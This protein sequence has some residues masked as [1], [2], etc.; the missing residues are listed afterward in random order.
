MILQ[1]YNSEDSWKF[2]GFRP[3]RAT[4]QIVP[5]L[6]TNAGWFWG[7]KNSLFLQVSSMGWKSL[8]FS[9]I[10]FFFP[11]HH[12]C[13]RHVVDPESHWKQWSKSNPIPSMGLAYLPTWMV[14]VYGFMVNNIPVLYQSHGWYGNGCFVYA[15]GYTTQLYEDFNQA[16]RRI[17]MNRLCGCNTLFLQNGH[18]LFLQDLESP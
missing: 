4:C 16:R 1:V 15:C 9:G 17:S 18:G 14:D 11:N 2:W 7:F 6:A 12:G 3:A 10:V 5:W 8:F 13:F